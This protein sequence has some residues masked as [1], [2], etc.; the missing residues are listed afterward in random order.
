MSDQKLGW[1][2]QVDS[3]VGAPFFE[4]PYCGRKV[5]GR[6]VLFAY[7]AYDK[8]PDCDKD[9]HFDNVKE[10]DWT[11]LDSYYGDEQ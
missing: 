11:Y 8:C 3:L 7:E 1:I 2:F 6:K 9:L 4:C 5:D 10:D